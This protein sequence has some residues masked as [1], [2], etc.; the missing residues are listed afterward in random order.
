MV[1]RGEVALIV[2]NKGAAVG[3]MN[4]AFMAPIVLMVTV[5]VIV[6]PI[7][8]K[9]AYRSDTDSVLELEH[10]ELQENYSEIQD[11]ELATQA[12]LDMHD[13]LQGKPAGGKK[14]P[15]KPKEAKASS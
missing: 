2:A 5:T 11:L 7:L 10:S 12:I 14:P 9:L 4:E 15:K 13:E 6:A 8:L 3:L 1:S